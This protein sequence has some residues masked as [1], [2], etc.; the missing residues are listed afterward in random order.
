[1][2]I[3]ILSTLESFV[4]ILF[5][6][7][8][9]AVIFGKVARIRSH[10]QVLFSDA[11]VIRYGTGVMAEHS[12]AVDDGS[13]SQM[14]GRDED[15]ENPNLSRHIPCPVLEFRVVNRLHATLGGE[16]IDGTMNI[17]ASIDE[18]Q[19]SPA[20]RRAARRG[21]R[22]RGRR[23]R[24]LPHHVPTILESREMKTID[25]QESFNTLAR[26]IREHARRHHHQAFDEDPTGR[27]VPRR[28]FSKLEIESPDH[29][30]FKRQWIA[31][32]VL[33]ATSPLL[34]E[35][36]RKIVRL[37]NGFWPKEMDDHESVHASIQFDQILVSLSGTS[38]VD[39]NSVYAQKVYDYEDINVGYSFVNILYRN[40]DD[41]HLLVDPTK[42]NDV[43]EQY[44][45]GGEPL[46]ITEKKH[47]TDMLVL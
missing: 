23:R 10:A 19:A 5:G 27:I 29:P 25:P 40:E 26:T 6:S 35:E 16:I 28:I 30:F 20:I 43:T 4:G 42:I 9:G 31:R 38:N 45:G 18:H 21:F 41:G 37:N 17:V 8:C 15:I 33:D 46:V 1:M 36:A 13:Q 34:T 14:S 3:T 24:K 11:I 22:R 12:E 7:F 47:F 2:A 39:A 32:H 44:G